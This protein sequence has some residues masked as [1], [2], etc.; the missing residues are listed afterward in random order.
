VRLHTVRIYTESEDP[1]LD[2][3]PIN[4]WSIIEVNVGIYCAS[5]PSL[6][7]LGSKG[8]YRKKAGCEYHSG[9]KSVV[10]FSEGSM[11]SEEGRKD[12]NIPLN[13][14]R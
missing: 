4:L 11:G 14:M 10:V 7:A 13:N 1:F 6:K 8:K 9:G 12:E 2:A 5:I 3:V